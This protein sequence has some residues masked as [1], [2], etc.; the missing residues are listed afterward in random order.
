MNSH[1]H[2]LKKR[3]SQT[4]Y[5]QRTNLDSLHNQIHRKSNSNKPYATYAINY[6]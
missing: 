6:V 1:G 4:T 3:V 5:G 2:F